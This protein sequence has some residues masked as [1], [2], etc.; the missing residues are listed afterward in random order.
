MPARKRH[1]QQP[2]HPDPVVRFGRALEREKARKRAEQIRVQAA[3]DEAKRQAKIAADHARRLAAARK[4]LD[5]AIASVKQHRGDHDVEAEYRAA[6][7]DVL[8][9][10]TGERPDWAPDDH[11]PDDHV[12]DEN[13]SDENVDVSGGVPSSDEGSVSAPE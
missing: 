5:R 1:K 8:E 10:E 3:H 11:I 12:S 6:K 4:R 2:E 13:V 7:A 9:L